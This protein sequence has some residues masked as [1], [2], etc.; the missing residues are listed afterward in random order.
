[1]T[2]AFPIGL[3]TA[4]NE[5]D[6]L[7]PSRQ[8]CAVPAIGIALWPESGHLYTDY[9]LWSQI[10]VMPTSDCCAV[11]GI[12]VRGFFREDPARA[13]PDI[14]VVCK[15]SDHRPVLDIGYT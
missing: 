9:L 1:M 15:F 5:E 14:L 2:A 4:G 12:H 11:Q 6:D 13:G 3:E 7:F 8:E 10:E